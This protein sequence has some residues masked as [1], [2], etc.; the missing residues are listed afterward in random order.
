MLVGCPAAPW[1]AWRIHSS[2]YMYVFMC[3]VYI[4]IL[5]EYRYIH[6]Y[7]SFYIGVCM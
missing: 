4:D 5:S 7:V 6:I 1:L 2:I 3:M